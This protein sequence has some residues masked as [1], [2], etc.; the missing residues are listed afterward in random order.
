MESS[1]VADCTLV[2][3]LTIFHTI[4]FCLSFYQS[5]VESWTVKD[6]IVWLKKEGFGDYEK[7]IEGKNIV[8]SL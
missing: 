8:I 7:K 4:L 3:T 6:V 2:R 5:A 1:N